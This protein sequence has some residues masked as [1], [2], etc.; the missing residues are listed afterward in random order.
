MDLPMSQWRIQ[1]FQWEGATFKRALAWRSE[2]PCFSAKR[3]NFWLFR[4]F[5]RLEG[6]IF[7]IF[8]MVE[9]FFRRSRAFFA[10]FSRTLR[11]LEKTTKLNLKILMGAFLLKKSC[12]GLPTRA[13]C[14][15]CCVELTARSANLPV[16]VYFTKQLFLSTFECMN[17]YYKLRNMNK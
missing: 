5:F 12:F 13:P 14:T 15:F 17:K 10:I 1:D 6:P 16:L 9:G 3:P 11:A 8:P 2:G 7:G 4:H